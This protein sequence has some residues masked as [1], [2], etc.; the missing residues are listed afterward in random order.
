M[1]CLP[2]SSSERG[3]D[4]APSESGVPLLLVSHSFYFFTFLTLHK[5]TVDLS[6]H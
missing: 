5:L 1:Y 6:A 2:K 3:L 4:R